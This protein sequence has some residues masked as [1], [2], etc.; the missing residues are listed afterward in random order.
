MARGTALVL[1]QKDLD[2]GSLPVRIPLEVVRTAILLAE[3]WVIDWRA[4]SL[5]QRF[6][7]ACMP[8]NAH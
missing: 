2:R 7:F 6:P 5:F 1:A 3:V 8:A 4:R